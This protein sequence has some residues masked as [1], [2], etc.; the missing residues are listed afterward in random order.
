MNS[1]AVTAELFPIMAR[2]KDFDEQ[3]VL[4]RAMNIF[5]SKGYQ[6]TSMEDL[7][8]GLGISRSSLYDTY[9][10]KHTLFIKALEN[11]QQIGGVKLREIFYGPGTAK[12]KV[13]KLME[14]ALFGVTQGTKQNGCFMLNAE[15]EVAPHD[16]KV[17]N[18]ICKKDQQMEDLFYQVIQKGKESG[19]IKNKHN[20]RI[21]ARFIFTAVK[22]LQVNATSKADLS[23]L[24]DLIA[25][26]VSTLD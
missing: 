17:N 19:E 4:D 14:Y 5:W 10:D 21:L 6:G 22:G 16:K 9:S 1:F 25:L 7:V 26:T 24:S 18:I 23:V 13:R 3:E 8:K 12:E 15:V 11:Y 20:A 2:T